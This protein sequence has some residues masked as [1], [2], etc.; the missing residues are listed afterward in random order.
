M[1]YTTWNLSYSRLASSDPDV[2]RLLKLLAYFDNQ[3]VWYELFSVGITVAGDLPIW[4][5]ELVAERQSFESAMGMLVDY[6]L[7]EVQDATQSYSMHNCVHDWALGEL[8]K[9]VD[10]QLYWYAFDCMIA[11][12]H[13]DDRDNLGQLK[14]A[15]LS[16]HGVRL[17]HHR[18][19]Q[20][21]EF[22]YGLYKRLKAAVF[23]AELLMEQV[24]YSAAERLYMRALAECEKILG[25]DHSSTLHTINHL[26]V[27]H[28]LQ[29]KPEKAERM[30][31]RALAGYEKALGPDHP[32]TL[33]TINN[34]S[35]L[36][37]RQGKLE[38]VRQMLKRA[39]AG[40][41]KALGLNHLSTLKTV[42]NLG[43]LYCDHGRLI[44]A[45]QM[46]ER[47]LAGIEKALGPDH[48]ST[49]KTANSLA[50][51]Y[52]NQGR[53]VEAE[54]MLER[55]VAGTEKALGREHPHTLLMIRNLS[56]CYRQQGKIEAAEQ[57]L[58]G[59]ENNDS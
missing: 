37:R 30:L 57:L 23:V 11:S 40:Y 12:I 10:P 42:R 32:S 16:R 35:G 31:K 58:K 15:R 51:L 6:C 54:Q 48:P 49:L 27:L 7:V 1:L 20:N 36:Y 3:E 59:T 21:N 4:L 38:M 24:Q 39:L 13:K 8:N 47:A 18:F 53:L 34:L 19:E 46:L 41:E 26:G 33:N 29:G 43:S 22:E 45:E 2:A 17:T 44:E 52:S 9:V 56:R 25:P 28:R 5:Q 14:Y 50:I 55:S